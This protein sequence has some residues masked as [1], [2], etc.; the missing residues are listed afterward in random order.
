MKHE[1]LS[2]ISQIDLYHIP[3]MGCVNSKT[4]NGAPE[5]VTNSTVGPSSSVDGSAIPIQ[6]TRNSTA[7]DP[8][9]PIGPPAEPFQ[10]FSPVVETQGSVY[11]A[12][13]AYQARTAE[14]LSFEKGEILKVIGNEEGDWWLAKSLKSQREGYIPSNYVA[15]AQTYE[16]EE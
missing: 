1:I 5:N 10:P 15:E 8:T 13:Y 6:P 12:R 11:I 3:A 4:N 2:E 14:D 9:S 16:A 7:Y